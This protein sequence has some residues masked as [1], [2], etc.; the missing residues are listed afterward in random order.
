MVYLETPS[1]PMMEVVDLRKI[2]DICK[3]HNVLTAVDSTI[4]SPLYLKGLDLGIDISIHSCTKYIGGHSDCVGGSI[5][6][7]N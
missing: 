6:T 3:K 2:A 4:S 5:S 1:N 7:N